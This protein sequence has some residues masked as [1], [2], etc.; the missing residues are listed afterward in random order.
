MKEYEC[1]SCGF[2]QTEH[3]MQ[4]DDHGN[5]CCYMCGKQIIYH[6][7]KRQQ[8]LAQDMSDEQL[9]HIIKITEEME[10]ED[11]W[12]DEDTER[13]ADYGQYTCWLDLAL[14]VNKRQLEYQRGQYCA[15]MEE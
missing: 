9:Q 11:P 10:R 13:H 8:Y 7:T 5:L 1:P 2:V 3:E 15:Q 6:L 14:D 4:E 12:T